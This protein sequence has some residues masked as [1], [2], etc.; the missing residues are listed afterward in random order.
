MLPRAR[1]NYSRFFV[2]L[3]HGHRMFWAPGKIE[4]MRLQLVL[5]AAM[6]AAPTAA[7]ADPP[8]RLAPYPVPVAPDGA[9]AVR[10]GKFVSLESHAPRAD[11]FSRG[12]QHELDQDR[13]GSAFG[14][15]YAPVA[16][17]AQVFARAGYGDGSGLDRA[18]IGESWKYGAGAEY[19]TG[20]RNGI[21]AD[22]TRYESGKT[23][24]KAN[25]VS[26]GFIQKF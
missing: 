14:V 4:V 16:K 11:N 25:V 17:N 22:F 7:L 23:R 5:L 21:R 19:S 1:S 10:L 18:N 8:N 20:P 12:L 2:L 26:L 13:T 6:I 3:S 9:S 15:A 24:P